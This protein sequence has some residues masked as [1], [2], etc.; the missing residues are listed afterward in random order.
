MDFWHRDATVW[1]CFLSNKVWNDCVMIKRYSGRPSSPLYGFMLILPY[2]H[3]F[4]L[5]VNFLWQVHKPVGETSKST[6]FTLLT[7]FSFPKVKGNFLRIIRSLRVCMWK[8]KEIPEH[9]SLL[10]F[11]DETRGLITEHYVQPCVHTLSLLV[12][13]RL[14]TFTFS[15]RKKNSEKKENYFFL[16]A[17]S[18]TLIAFGKQ[19]IMLSRRAK[20][21]KA[22]AH[23]YFK[24]FI[25]LGEQRRKELRMSSFWIGENCVRVNPQLDYL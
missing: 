19:K 8:K 23:T 13:L 18:N 6:H 4:I 20:E 21:K 24:A 14:L 2:S 22:A 1:L 7:S 5:E 25:V 9:T 15:L 12:F 16:L 17:S 3:M 11:R 10:Q